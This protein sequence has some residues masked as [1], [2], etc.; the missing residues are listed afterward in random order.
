MLGFRKCFNRIKELSNIDE[1]HT[2]KINS[3]EKGSFITPIVVFIAENKDI[4]F[5]TAIS[6]LIAIPSFILYC[7]E[8]K[9]HLKE[10]SAK[11]INISKKEDIEITNQ[12]GITIRI[13]TDNSDLIEKILKD[14]TMQKGLSQMAKPLRENNIDKFKLTVD[15]KNTETIVYEEKKYFNYSS[16]KEI[17][18]NEEKIN[19]HIRSLD[20]QTNNGK[21]IYRK[22]TYPMSLQ[23]ENPKEYYKF[24][25]TELQV[26]IECKIEMNED[27]EIEKILVYDIYLTKNNQLEINNDEK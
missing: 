17:K 9:K 19:G 6:S 25:A 27:L 24:F 5:P 11:K 1:K 16:Q 7:I 15:K 14:E 12:E 22:K 18:T 13:K 23:M 2:L 8:I 20:K 26:T 4:L 10:K 3:F 21:F